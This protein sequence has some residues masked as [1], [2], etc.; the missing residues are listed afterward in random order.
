MQFSCI[1]AWQNSAFCVQLLNSTKCNFNNGTFIRSTNENLMNE[2]N[3][4]QREL[5]HLK[6]TV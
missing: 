6:S 5:K 1:Y 2:Q 4:H 3:A